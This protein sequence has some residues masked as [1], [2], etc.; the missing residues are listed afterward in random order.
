M[1]V[2]VGPRSWQPV[3]VDELENAAYEVVTSTANRSVVAGPG[4]GKTEILA[5][6]ACFLLETG[7][8]P[9]PRRILAIS[10]KR[11]AANN[12]RDRVN[13]RIG[14][15]AAFRFDSVTFDSFAKRL[16]DRFYLGLNEQ[17]RPDPDYNI[18]LNSSAD[19]ELYLNTLNAPPREL[20]GSWD[21]QSIN[22][23]TFEKR[24][25]VRTTLPEDG[26]SPVDVPSWACSQY[27]QDNLQTPSHLSFPM[28]GRL[29]ELLVRLNPRLAAALRAT[30]SHVLL[31]EFQDTTHVQY[32]LIKTIFFGSDAVLTAVGDHKQQIM[33]W[34][35]ALTDA[36]GGFEADFQANQTEF[37]N[38]YRSSE[39][40]VRIGHQIAL[41]V[42]GETTRGESKVENAI[43]GRACEVLVFPT[44]ESENRYLADMING[45]IG[46]GQLAPRDFAVLV[47]VRAKQ[48]ADQLI[49]AFKRCGLLLRDEGAFQDALAENIV[50]TL[51]MF[52]RLGSK[53]RAGANWLDCAEITAGIWGLDQNDVPGWRILE[54]K[55]NGLHVS[56]REEMVDLPKTEHQI[57]RM[58]LGILQ[59]LDVDDV[60]AFFP[61]YAQS[62]RLNDV[63]A[64]VGKLLFQS[65]SGQ[66]DWLAAL[67]DFE[68]R[69]STP[70]MTVH[71]SKGLE[72]H[73][74]IVLALD[75]VAWWNFK[76]APQEEQPAFFVAFSRAKQRV[77]FTYCEERGDRSEIASLYEILRSAGVS[78]RFI[79]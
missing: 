31:D 39:E 73:T 23:K 57:E 21:I 38:N 24:Y 79:P 10:F 32:D 41:A 30:Y 77:I 43:D 5:Q 40:L 60:K 1:P 6:R 12:L 4:A 62:E 50:E 75:D 7:V 33:L 14:T 78:T 44:I 61:E 59:F 45:S 16:L 76:R 3:G 34:A 56:L 63:V 47:R 8:I 27:W 74:V 70:L 54:R 72:Y 65:C 22:R 42:D 49:P 68:G 67:D 35:M 20:G 26:F 11:D 13:T 58:L 36:F 37:V 17:W 64:S 48:Y 19:I 28:I 55:L 15:D 71:K 18:I 25:I 29:V 66:E 9:H 51:L 69:Y 2:F 52:L 46:D 53:D